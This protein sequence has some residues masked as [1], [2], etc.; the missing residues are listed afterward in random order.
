MVLSIESPDTLSWI[1]GAV[2]MLL[3]VVLP[4]CYMVLRNKKA[5]HKVT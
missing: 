5:L 4:L 2:I 3:G 1:I